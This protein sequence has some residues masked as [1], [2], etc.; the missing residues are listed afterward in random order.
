MCSSPARQADNR[1]PDMASC[2]HR[3]FCHFSVCVRVRIFRA[4]QK[5]IR[6]QLSARACVCV[7]FAASQ[8]HV[9]NST[10]HATKTVDTTH[11]HTHTPKLLLLLFLLPGK[12]QNGNTLPSPRSPHPHMRALYAVHERMCR[13]R[14]CAH[15]HIC[16]CKT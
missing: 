8:S 15:E 4:T 10:E 9:K 16:I 11:S 13:M 3:R 5:R 14:A 12:Q 2:I 1:K 6:C 7:C